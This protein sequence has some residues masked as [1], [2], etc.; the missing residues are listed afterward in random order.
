MIFLH[1]RQGVFSSAAMLTSAGVVI[2]IVVAFPA[3]WILDGEIADQSRHRA[4]ARV[5]RYNSMR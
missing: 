2:G 3:D 1:A 4:Q 5:N